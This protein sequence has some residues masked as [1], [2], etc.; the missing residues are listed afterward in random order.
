MANNE[1]SFYLAQTQS[2]DTISLFQKEE[3]FD[4][5]F[6][7]SFRGLKKAVEV[8]DVLFK[9]ELDDDDYISKIIK[10]KAN[11]DSFISNMVREETSLLF[12]RSFELYGN[13]VDIDAD[14]RQFLAI[15]SSDF[16]SY[17]RNVWFSFDE[18]RESD[19][20]KIAYD[21]KIVYS[22]IKELIGGE[23]RNIV[24]I[25]FMDDISLNG[26]QLKNIDEMA[27]KIFDRV[28]KNDLSKKSN[29]KKR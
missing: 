13:I 10:N 4:E 8:E 5:D 6:K 20:S 22:S 12:K 19:L 24:K 21:S 15:M 18:I 28:N 17:K 14:N 3:I 26:Y 25:F 2:L 11:F 29:R 23:Q 1:L 27:K 7:A 16:D 9:S